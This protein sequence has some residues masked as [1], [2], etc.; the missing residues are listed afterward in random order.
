VLLRRTL[1]AEFGIAIVVLGVTGALA[2]YPPGKV[3]DVGPVSE[4]AV[5]GPARLELTIDPARAGSNE[6]HIYFFERASGAQWDAAKDL[7]AVATLAG[8]DIDA[9]PIELRKAGPGHY[10]AQQATFP[11]AGDW[12]LRFTARVSDFDQYEATVKVPIR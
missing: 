9:L 4:R 12:R 3:A 10:V 8:R 5:L 7:T 2:T 11:A 1:R 6:L